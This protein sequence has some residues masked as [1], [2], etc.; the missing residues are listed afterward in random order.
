[1][2]GR[3][4]LEMVTKHGSNKCNMSWRRDWRWQRWN[5]K[6]NW[7]GIYNR[8][9]PQRQKEMIIHFRRSKPPLQ[10]VNTCG[11]DIE[12]VPSYKYLGVHL[13]NKLDWSLNTDALYKKGHSRLFFLRKLRSLDICSKMLQMFYQS[14]VA[15]VLFYAAVCWGGSIRHKDARRLDKLV[16]RAGS[17]IGVRLDTLEEVVERCTLK[18]SKAIVNNP[19]YPLHNTLMDQKKL[20][21]MAPLSSMQDGE[22]QKILYPI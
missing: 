11:V 22:I 5:T 8:A 2:R 19:G 4:L 16:K 15:S 13:D 9:T 12:V 3:Q 21:W 17:V 10:P 20:W 7:R 1:M 18:M 6:R 14:V